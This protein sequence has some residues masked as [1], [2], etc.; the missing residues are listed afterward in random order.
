LSVIKYLAFLYENVAHF[1]DS[2]SLTLPA[3]L[4]LKL[5]FLSKQAGW[6]TILETDR[7]AC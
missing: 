7:I 1:P 2:L 4:R 6:E 5:G 3:V